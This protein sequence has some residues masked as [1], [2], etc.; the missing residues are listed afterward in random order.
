MG[1]TTKI[2]VEEYLQT[3]YRPDVE[4]VDGEIQERNGGEIEH[5]RLIAAV[6]RWFQRHEREWSI[7]VL[8]DVRIQVG[9]TRYRVPD[10]CVS[11]SSSQDRRIVTTPPLLV[12]EVLSP[13][14]R[15]DRYHQRITEYREM[16]VQ[17]IWVLD[18]ETH[19]GWDCSTGNWME[20]TQFQLP[21]S[22]IHL[23]LNA[24]TAL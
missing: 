8:P 14:D 20:G 24:I 7:E 2:S 1:A 4:Y 21:N 6:M 3:A 19:R 11:I 15:I 16:G 22:P 10:V 17:G 18:P 12:V 13:E 23:D 5:A 9:P